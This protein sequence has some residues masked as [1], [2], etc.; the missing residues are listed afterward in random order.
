[1]TLTRPEATRLFRRLG[2]VTA[3]GERGPWANTDP[4]AAAAATAA[5]AAATA[6]GNFFT[7]QGVNVPHAAAAA[8]T[9]AAAPAAANPASTA[10][11][12]SAAAGNMPNMVHV[13]TC[14]SEAGRC[15]LTVSKLDLKARLVSELEP[16]M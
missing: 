3:E 12:A 9:A 2:D 5:T 13:P 16:K 14:L 15:R 10:T 7:M 8:A 1:M 4:A 6:A 11:A